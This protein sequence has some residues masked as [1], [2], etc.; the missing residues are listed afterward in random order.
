M[1]NGTA[2][3]KTPDEVFR[4]GTFIGKSFKEI[5]DVGFFGSRLFK[6]AMM[7]RWNI[8]HRLDYSGGLLDEN[9]YLTEVGFFK[10]K[11]AA[12]FMIRKRALA[13][14]QSMNQA[15]I[16]SHLSRVASGGNWDSGK[17]GEYPGTLYRY[18]H[19]VSSLT[20]RLFGYLTH[21]SKQ[22][23]IY[24]PSV[25]PNLDGRTKAPRVFLH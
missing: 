17:K 9:P 3:K 8:P 2:K 14:G 20:F 13:R 18:T 23:L 4:A 19:T 16:I 12:Y 22:L 21:S 25:S 15:E 10:N 24:P 7:G 5:E 11:E 6:K 1:S